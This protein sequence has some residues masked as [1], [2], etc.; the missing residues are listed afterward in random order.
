MNTSVR[1]W[2]PTEL[3]PP[4]RRISMTDAIGQ[5][6][7]PLY[8]NDVEGTRTRATSIDK[9]SSNDGSVVVD[10]VLLAALIKKAAPQGLLYWDPAT[11]SHQELGGAD[12][13]EIKGHL[14]FVQRRY[15]IDM[16]SI[17]ARRAEFLAIQGSEEAAG[18]D[19][20]SP[21]T[22]RPEEN[23]ESSE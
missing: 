5:V 20:S 19:E 12:V 15:G 7:E 3:P 23:G 18:A 21:N 22:R 13:A 2:V 10:R 1:P 6:L 4:S 14:G 8:K 16:A 17:T 11:E 9:E